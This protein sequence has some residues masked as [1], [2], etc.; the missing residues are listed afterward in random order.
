MNGKRKSLESRATEYISDEK[1]E[2]V[3]ISALD[4]VHNVGVNYWGNKELLHADPFINFWQVSG[5]N[6]NETKPASMLIF[7]YKRLDWHIEISDS[8]GNMLEYADIKNEHS[9]Y[10]LK[11]YPSKGEYYV[12]VTGTDE[13][14][15]SLTSEPKK[16]TVKH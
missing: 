14:G 6:I 10:G 3:M 8:E 5:T 4:G 1:P 2:I 13:K 16:I 15:L 7:G 11:W 9:I 12:T